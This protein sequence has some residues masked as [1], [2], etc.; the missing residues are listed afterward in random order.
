MEHVPISLVA[1]LA[2]AIEELKDLGFLVVGLDGEAP[3]ELAGIDWAQRVALVLGAEGK[4]LAAAHA[5][6]L[7]PALPD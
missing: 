4:V 6:A 2:R 3:Q 7:R 1:N 5:G